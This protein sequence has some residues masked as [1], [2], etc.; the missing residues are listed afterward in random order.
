MFTIIWSHS[1]SWHCS[2]WNE[3]AGV[4][5]KKALASRYFWELNGSLLWPSNE[6]KV[7]FVSR[8]GAPQQGRTRP[9]ASI[10][11]FLYSHWHVCPEAAGRSLLG[12]TLKPFSKAAVMFATSRRCGNGF[13]FS[14]G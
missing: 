12:A 10:T 3:V 14:G 5:A 4:P 2:V 11:M 6:P 1:Q 9:L 7:S 13:Q 8:R